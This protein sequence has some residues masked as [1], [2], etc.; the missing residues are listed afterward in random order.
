VAK[1][2]FVES[3]S[4]KKKECE[5]VCGVRK[6]DRCGGLLIVTSVFRVKKE[7][8]FHFIGPCP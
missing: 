6:W 1:V 8:N 4:E 2:L 5:G 7:F 3:K